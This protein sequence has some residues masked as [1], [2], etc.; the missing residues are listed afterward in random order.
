MRIVFEID[1]NLN[2]LNGI[3][4]DTGTLIYVTHDLSDSTALCMATKSFPCFSVKS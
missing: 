2:P 1:F 4:T 3:F